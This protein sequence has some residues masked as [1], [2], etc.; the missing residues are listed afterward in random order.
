MK[1][2]QSHQRQPCHMELEMALFRFV[3][4]LFC[5]LNTS[6]L[7][8]DLTK[9]KQMN[10]KKKT[11]KLNDIYFIGKPNVCLMIASYHDGHVRLYT[12]P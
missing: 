8:A 11:I 7:V 6:T 9:K 10:K 4:I 5:S 12:L 2:C 1:K 3:S